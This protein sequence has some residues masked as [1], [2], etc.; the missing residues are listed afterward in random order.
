ML[1][2]QP[3]LISIRL[4][5]AGSVVKTTTLTGIANGTN[6]QIDGGRFYFTSSNKVYS[7]DM[8]AANSAYKSYHYSS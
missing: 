4:T 3:I 7:M 6:L 8:N 5:L 2:E 1:K